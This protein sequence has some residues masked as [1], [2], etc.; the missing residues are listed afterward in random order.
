VIAISILN[1]K[2]F[3]I[4]VGP[5]ISNIHG[6]LDDT[7]LEN[8]SAIAHF[9]SDMV[10]PCGKHELL[11]LITFKRGMWAHVGVRLCCSYVAVKKGFKLQHIA[12]DFSLQEPKS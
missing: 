3:G 5:F 7:P 8:M 9:R 11:S 1:Q 12:I 10:P 2:K 4:R 6:K